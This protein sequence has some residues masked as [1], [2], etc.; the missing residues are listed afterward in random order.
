MGACF[1]HPGVA[2]TGTCDD[3]KTPICMRCTKGTLDGFMC[4]PCAHKR[5]GRRKLITG[6]KVAGVAALVVALAVGGLV[7]V[8]KGSQRT[9]PPVPKLR[10]PDPAIAA[11]LDDRDLAPCDRKLIR[12][13]V[14]ALGK[15]DRYADVVEHAGAFFAKCGPFP[16]LEW[17]VVY[18]LQQLGRYAE[19][20][21]HETVIIEDNPFDSDFWWWRGEDRARSNQPDLALADYRQSFANSNGARAG[22]F[23]ASRVLDVAGPAGRPCEGAW[24]MRFFTE[25]LGGD[26]SDDLRRQ[27]DGLAQAAQCET[28]DGAGQVTLRPAATDATVRA[29]VTIGGVA[30]TF[31]VDPRCGTT[32]LT[33]DYATRA[34]V[35]AGGPTIQTVANNVLRSGALG[36]AALQ[37]GDARASAVEVVVVDGLPPGVDGYL[38]LSFLWKFAEIDLTDGVRVTAAA[39]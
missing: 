3:C 27:A 1:A 37:V 2:A 26:I 11:L 33:R 7:I 24:A 18:A 30:G 13:L 31:V 6:L 20:V 15:L 22:R 28:V 12:T 29:E 4:P 10:D 17:S 19:A 23:P 21:K 25:T 32:V 39:P 9:K 36:A 35:V 34:Q 8:G 16:R 14:D 5:Y 38:G